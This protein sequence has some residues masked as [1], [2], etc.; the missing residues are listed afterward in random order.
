MGPLAF[1]TRS[2]VKQDQISCPSPHPAPWWKI[3]LYPGCPYT[4]SSQKKGWPRLLGQSW[5]HTQRTCAQSDPLKGTGFLSSSFLSYTAV[6]VSKITRWL[7]ITQ[8]HTHTEFKHTEQRF[9]QDKMSHDFSEFSRKWVWVNSGSWQWTERPGVLQSMGS[10]RVGHDREA[11]LSW[12][13]LNR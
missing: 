7:N 12:T 9:Y 10:Q 13:E 3:H 1:F 5:P 2:Q 8:A 6:Y 4:L 11:E